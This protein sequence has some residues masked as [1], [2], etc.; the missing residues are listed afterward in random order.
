ML[1]RPREAQPFLG[2]YWQ[3]PQSL[4]LSGVSL[5]PHCSVYWQMPSPHLKT[6]SWRIRV[7]MAR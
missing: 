2:G 3:G 1:L 5:V 4:Q 6:S 7:V